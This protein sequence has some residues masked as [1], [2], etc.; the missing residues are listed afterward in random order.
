MTIKNYIKREQLLSFKELKT[1][2]KKEKKAGY[3]YFLHFQ[4]NSGALLLAIFENRNCLVKIH[5]LMIMATSP[6]N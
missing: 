6:H 4:Q 5:S 2:L 1:L 3:Q